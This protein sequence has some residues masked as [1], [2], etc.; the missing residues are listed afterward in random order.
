MMRAISLWE[1]YASAMA[2]GVKHNETR[3]RDTQIRGD[4][5]IHV[6]RLPLTRFGRSNP[7]V[8]LWE[9]LQAITQTKLDCRFGHII[10][11]VDLYATMTSQDYLAQHYSALEAPWGDYS[12][13]RWVWRTRNPRP[14]ANPILTR[15]HQG[16]WFL[17]PDV[18]TAIRQQLN[19]VP[20]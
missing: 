17:P 19:P 2:L 10:C 14:L 20:A 8:E 5:A 11:V 9:K 13:D 16:F 12:I 1:P 6:A 3:G 7:R 15:G 18:E 4:L